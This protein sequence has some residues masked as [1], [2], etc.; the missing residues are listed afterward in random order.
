MTGLSLQ[1]QTRLSNQPEAWLKA[2]EKTGPE[3]FGFH[4]LRHTWA[5]WYVQAGT[6]SLCVS[7]WHKSGTIRKLGKTK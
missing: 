1:W 4:D 5:S 7:D 2:L 6:T 3:G